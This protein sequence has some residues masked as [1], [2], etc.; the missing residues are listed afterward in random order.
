MLAPRLWLWAAA[1]LV[2]EQTLHAYCKRCR[3]GKSLLLLPDSSETKYQQDLLK[4][5]LLKTPLLLSQ[6]VTGL[7]SKS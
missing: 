5:A 1:N 7:K 3:A 2:A 4:G 6:R